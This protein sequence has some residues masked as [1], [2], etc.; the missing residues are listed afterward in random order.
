MDGLVVDG[1]FAAEQLPKRLAGLVP[2]CDPGREPAG[3]FHIDDLAPGRDQQR[4]LRIGPGEQYRRLVQ[5]PADGGGMAA[6]RVG[7]ILD[8]PEPWYRTQWYDL[9]ADGRYLE[10]RTREHVTVRPAGAADLTAGFADWIDRALRR[11]REDEPDI[12]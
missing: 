5:R 7:S 4:S 1:E 2:S 12:W 9:T 3:T 8:R 11:L 6:L 10:K